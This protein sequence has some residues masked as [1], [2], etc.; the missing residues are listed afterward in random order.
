MGRTNACLV[1]LAEMSDPA[2]SAAVEFNQVEKV[3][4]RAIEYL[5]RSF[6]W[7]V[8]LSQKLGIDLETSVWRKYP[9]VCPYC[10][11][12]HRE[13][14]C[15][16][17][18]RSKRPIDLWRLRDIANANANSVPTNLRDWESMF[19][20]IYPGTASMGF[21][22]LS[23]KLVEELGE[24]EGELTKPKKRR[25]VL[26]ETGVDTFAFEIADFSA[27]SCQVSTAL[28]SPS[29]AESEMSVLGSA[30]SSV[31]QYEICP[32]CLDSICSCDIELDTDEE[33]AMAYRFL[34]PALHD[35][36][37]LRW[38]SPRQINLGL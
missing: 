24:V 36:R 20:S 27:W 33:R 7:L 14:N 19:Q 6:I 21:G 10:R 16:C 3:K 22:Y 15:Q 23:T 25:L 1:E 32:R 11:E 12:K 8:S 17:S 4:K 30:L 28:R 26:R 35:P 38:K 2:K 34:D 9:G 13:T 37:D 29:G 5:A 18:K 31:L